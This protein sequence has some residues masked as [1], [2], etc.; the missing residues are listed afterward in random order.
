MDESLQSMSLEPI[1]PRYFMFLSIFVV[2]L[3]TR[4]NAAHNSHFSVQSRITEFRALVA[5]ALVATAA[6]VYGLNRTSESSM[7]LI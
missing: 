1:L 4:E 5:G 7:P 2:F 6:L 3:W